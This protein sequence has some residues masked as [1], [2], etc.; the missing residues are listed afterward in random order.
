MR[1][2]MRRAAGD[3][4]RSGEA[5]RFAHGTA[6]PRPCLLRARPD[7]FIEAAE[8][9]DIRLL[10]PRFERTPDEEAR[11]GGIGRA[12]H[13]AGEQAPIEG[14]VGARLDGEAVA[15]FDQ[16][17]EQRRQSLACVVLPEPRR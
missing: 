4:L 11:M 13:L 16:L 6:E 14:R 15:S 10:E 7:P 5:E 1:E 8:D 2:I 3:L 17:G 12:D 9:H